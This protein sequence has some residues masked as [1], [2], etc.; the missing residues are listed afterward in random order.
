MSAVTRTLEEQEVIARKR[1]LA[2][3]GVSSVF[4]YEE[5]AR[6]RELQVKELQARRVF[7]TGQLTRI[8]GNHVDG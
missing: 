2:A 3:T 1:M 8:E 5:W 7:E 6:I 4:A